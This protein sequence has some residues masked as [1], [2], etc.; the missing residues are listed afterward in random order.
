MSFIFAP[1][2]K[3]NNM[4]RKVLWALV[5]ALGGANIAFSMDGLKQNA[6]MTFSGLSFAPLVST[7]LIGWG[8]LFIICVALN[9]FCWLSFSTFITNP[10]AM[11]LVVSQIIGIKGDGFL[12]IPAIIIGL[13]L[14]GLLC[15]VLYYCYWFD[16]KTTGAG[17]GIITQGPITS[18]PLIVPIAFT[19]F[20]PEA[21]TF[22][23]HASER[24]EEASGAGKV[25][26]R[27]SAGSLPN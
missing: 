18:N 26:G 5:Y 9:Y 3:T 14:M 27:S 11:P 15:V 8:L 24:V 12:K 21:M 23:I 4:K 2:V 10:L 17:L 22:V 20:G 1:D 19:V 13:L 7:G 25:S 6:N 16:L